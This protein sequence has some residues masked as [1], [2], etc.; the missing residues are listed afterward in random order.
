MRLAP[1]LHRIG[2][3]LVAAYLVV[4]P[5][6]VTVVDAALAGHWREL[7]AELATVGR[8][9]ADVRGVVLTHGDTDHL[10]F[11]ERLRRDHGVPVHVHR[12]DADRARGRVKAA[13]TWGRVNPVA[14]ARFLA[15]AARRGGLRT[16]YLTEVVEVDDGQVLDLPGAPRVIGLPGH[17]PGSVAVHVSSV[18]ALFVGDALTTRHVLTGHRGAQPAPF[19]DDPDGALAS[20]EQL[21]GLEAAWVLPGHGTPWTAGVD[22]AVRAVRAAAPVGRPR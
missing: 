22:A 6:G 7:V 9:P 13:A 3:D 1:G 17:S 18:G 16:T 14:T 4:T 19:T 5:D 15:Y 12:A 21:A 2:N 8:T 11:A 10:G 20:L